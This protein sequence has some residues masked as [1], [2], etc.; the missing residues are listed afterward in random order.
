MQPSNG[1]VS[2]KE[3]FNLLHWKCEHPQDNKFTMVHLSG[4]QMKFKTDNSDQAKVT[5]TKT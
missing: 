5:K 3:T 4:N 1:D 2:A